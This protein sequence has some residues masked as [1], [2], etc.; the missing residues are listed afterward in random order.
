MNRW[1]PPGRDSRAATTVSDLPCV[2]RTWPVWTDERVGVA[3]SAPYDVQQISQVLLSFG[4][5]VTPTV[6]VDRAIR[7]TS[8]PIQVG[9]GCHGPGIRLQAVRP[10]SPAPRR[11]PAGKAS[12]GTQ[13]LP[14]A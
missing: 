4:S 10:P 9:G 1:W 3:D 8:P 13:P 11:W 14:D 12:T 5:S 2:T 6:T 7:R